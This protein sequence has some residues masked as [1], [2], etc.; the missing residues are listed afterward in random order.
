[1]V[2]TSSGIYNYNKQTE[3][4]SKKI[5]DLIGITKN[6]TP[7]SDEF[8]FHFKEKPDYRYE[9]PDRKEIIKILKSTFYLY[10]ETNLPIYGVTSPSLIQYVR[11]DK[12]SGRSL[13]KKEARLIDEDLYFEGSK[14]NFEISELGCILL[15]TRPSETGE[16]I[17]D[18]IKI[19]FG[20]LCSQGNEGEFTAI[21]SKNE[22]FIMKAI[23]KCNFLYPIAISAE[24]VKT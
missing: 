18:G 22:T 21:T 9:S 5:Y 13:P 4:W 23:E 3:K 17:L 19:K 15:Y 20:N 7:K 12:L 1:M 16:N 11:A 24:F 8:I 6:L 14:P 2:I 10:S